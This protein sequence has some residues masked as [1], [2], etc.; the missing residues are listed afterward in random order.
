MFGF[1]LSS[2]PSGSGH[3]PPNTSGPDQK[4][5]IINP[6]T[7]AIIDKATKSLEKILNDNGYK[8]LTENDSFGPI[9]DYYIIKDYP[10]KDDPNKGGVL[11]LLKTTCYAPYGD[12][13]KRCNLVINHEGGQ[14][15]FATYIKNVWVRKWTNMFN[16]KNI[17]T[18]V[19]YDLSPGNVEVKMSGG[20]TYR[21][22]RKCN[23]TRR[24]K[25]RRRKHKK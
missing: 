21:K 5:R 22:G 19:N 11:K 17:E 3:R 23:K 14:S 25:T 6:K 12:K 2:G 1:K 8:R 24:N 9:G 13:N 15:Q 10:H 7:D 20:K 4:P 18:Q 16:R